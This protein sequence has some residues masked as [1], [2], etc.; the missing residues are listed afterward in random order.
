MR[1]EGVYAQ[2]GRKYK[3]RK[4]AKRELE[5]TGNLLVT[6]PID[7]NRINQ[8][9]YADIIFIPTNEGWLYLAAVMDAY[10]RRIVGYAMNDNMKTD[11]II[12][13]LRMVIRQR[14]ARTRFDSS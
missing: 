8:V 4:A 3:R 1:R 6:N 10:S 5:N 11:L 14:R 13:A 7:I 12:Q 2:L 9:Y